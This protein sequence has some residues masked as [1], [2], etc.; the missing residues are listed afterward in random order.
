MTVYL[1]SYGKSNSAFKLA[2]ALNIQRIVPCKT[3]FLGD[4]DILTSQYRYRDE[5][6][7]INWGSSSTKQSWIQQVI[8]HPDSVFNTVDK[9]ATFEILKVNNIPTV[10][11]TVNKEQAQEW[12]L[13]GS[14]VFVRHNVKGKQ[15]EGITI[16]RESSEAL[17]DA[18]LYTKAENTKREYRIHIMNKECIDL[19]AKALRKG[20]EINEIKS[21][22]NGYIF[23]RQDIKI[24]EYVKNALISL[25]IDTLEVL[26]LSFGAVDIL[27][28]IDNELMILEVNSAPGIEGT[29]LEKYV[30]GFRNLVRF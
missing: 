18:M 10:K 29:T 12:L 3:K 2:K 11:W 20:A 30:K 24:P 9:R 26:N 19:T 4:M 14:G 1:R 8:N 23:A 22:N 6:I 7:I 21:W 5:D 27:R 25:A 13:E 28:N 16:I 17:P 15:G